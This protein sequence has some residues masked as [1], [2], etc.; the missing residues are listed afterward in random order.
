MD[1]LILTTSHS[2]TYLNGNYQYKVADGNFPENYGQF[3]SKIRTAVKR[4][5]SSPKPN[6][7]LILITHGFA[8]RELCQ[9]S[10]LRFESQLD[11]CSYQVER[12][13]P[14]TGRRTVIRPLEA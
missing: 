6:R 13:D 5:T 8:V 10:G 11:Y 12:I 4:L 14:L 3:Q 9:N 7:C 2:K 1:K